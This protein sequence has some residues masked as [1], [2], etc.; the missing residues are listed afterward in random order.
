M[1]K[2][3][4]AHG[5]P[6]DRRGRSAVAADDPMVSS[7]PGA[8]SPMAGPVLPTPLLPVIAATSRLVAGA[9]CSR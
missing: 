3:I 9:R 5:A 2:T 1:M 6:H 4:Q 7:A 8:R